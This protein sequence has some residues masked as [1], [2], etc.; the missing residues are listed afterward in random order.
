MP[1]AYEY[2]PLDDEEERLCNRLADEAASLQVVWVSW[3][4][5]G[6]LA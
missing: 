6:C 3:E 4:Y 1:L 5:Q 2:R